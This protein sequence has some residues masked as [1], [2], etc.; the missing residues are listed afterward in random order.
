V[1]RPVKPR[2]YRSP[3]R[4]RRAQETRAA[5]LD[6]ALRL[7]TAHGYVKTRL[8][9]V[10]AE[11]GVSLAT[12]KLVF[13]T[14]TDLLLA[15]WHRTLAGGVDDQ[16]PVADRPWMRAVFEIADPAEKLRQVAGNT[17]M[18]RKRVAEL[19]RVFEAAAAVDEEI[20][21]L[22][23]RMSREYYANQRGIIED[24]DR[25][26]HLRPGLSV[27]E[28]TDILWSI[29]GGR[30]YD[31]LVHERGWTPDRFERWLAGALR[32]ELLAD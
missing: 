29:N 6:A 22:Q 26:G 10:A 8:A 2:P 9:D 12:V 21:R 1:S 13:G 7:F 25:G 3:L 11:A 27:A 15:L 14:K 31:L 17:V 16:V 18:V 23:S 20:A 28:A 19:A 5:I 24:L 32:R 30:V 4:E